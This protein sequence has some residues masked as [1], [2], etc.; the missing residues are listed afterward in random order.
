MA[1]EKFHYKHGKKTITL[2]KF[3][4]V[5]TT[6]GEVR[7]LRHMP[8]ADQLF[9]AIEKVADEETLEVIDSMSFDELGEFTAAWQKDSGVTLGESGA[10]ATS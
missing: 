6:V 1:L 5:F 7:R 10:S 8:V 2:T 9:A 4:D 3:G